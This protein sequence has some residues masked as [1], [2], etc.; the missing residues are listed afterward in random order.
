MG[1]HPRLAFI[2]LGVTAAALVVVVM[3]EEVDSSDITTTL[4]LIF[5][6]DWNFGGWW[7]KKVVQSPRGPL[8]AT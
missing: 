7:R 5:W 3:Q 2:R 6:C 8:Q 4:R 1:T